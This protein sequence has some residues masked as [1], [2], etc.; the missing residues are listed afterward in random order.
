MAFV[1]KTLEHVND[2]DVHADG[3]VGLP[4]PCCRRILGPGVIVA[5]LRKSYLRHYV[6]GIYEFFDDLGRMDSTRHWLSTNP[7]WIIATNEHARVQAEI[8]QFDS[9]IDELQRAIRDEL[10]QEVAI[11]QTLPSPGSHVCA[12]DDAPPTGSSQGSTECPTCQLRRRLAELQAECNAFC[13]IRDRNRVDLQQS[14]LNTSLL[15][16]KYCRIDTA[17]ITD[18]LRTLT[19][20]RRMQNLYRWDKYCAQVTFSTYLTQRVGYLLGVESRADWLMTIVYACRR[21]NLIRDLVEGLQLACRR[22]SQTGVRRWI[23][24]VELSQCPYDANFQ[25]DFMRCI[26]DVA[27]CDRRK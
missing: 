16:A 6:G 18:T 21:R 17:P 14:V 3:G 13:S 5:P 27:R 22:S 26:E 20:A 11:R 4:C 23:H 15:F 7:M 24:R 25:A 19:G 12:H 8:D 9:I 2:L 10:K 1:K